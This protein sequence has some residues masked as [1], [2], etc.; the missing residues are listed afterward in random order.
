V[1]YIRAFDSRASFALLGA[2]VTERAR[3][4]VEQRDPIS[5][6]HPDRERSKPTRMALRDAA[7]L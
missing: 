6:Q 3:D 2:M 1:F 7:R 5:H 4:I